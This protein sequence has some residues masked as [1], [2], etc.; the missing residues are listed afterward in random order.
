MSIGK[1]QRMRLS[2]LTESEHIENIR[3]LSLH[4]Q[5][6]CHFLVSSVKGTFLLFDTLFSS[7]C[8]KECSLAATCAITLTIS[9]APS[10]SCGHSIVRECQR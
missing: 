6:T 1:K 4:P 2:Y 8:H 10:I 7:C 9:M 3:H 5:P